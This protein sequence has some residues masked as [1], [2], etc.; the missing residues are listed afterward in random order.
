MEEYSQLQT[1]IN[2]PDKFKPINWLQWSKEFEN[3]V[4]QYKTA[5]KT[6]VLIS[7][8]IRNISKRPDAAAMALLT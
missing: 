3:Y 8:V 6:G 2:K 5:Q 1:S 4:A 7:Y